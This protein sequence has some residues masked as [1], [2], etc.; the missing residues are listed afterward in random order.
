M[1]NR[2]AANDLLGK[3]IN[4]WKVIAKLPKPNPIKNETGGNFS[5]CY[6][7][8]KE[9]KECFMKVLDYEKSVMGL[10]PSGWTRTMYIQRATEE[11][12]YEKE[13]SEYCRN[14]HVSNVVYYLDSGELELPGYS[15]MG[16]VSFI[17]YEKAK[18]DIRKILDFSRRI[19]LAAKLKSLS[20]RLKS[21]H[22]TAVGISQLHN[23]AVSHQDIKPSNI[24]VFE[25][26]SKLGDLG[27]SLCLSSDVKCPYNLEGFNG[28]WTY[29]PPEAF[30]GFLLPDIR[31]RLYQMDNYMLGG[32]VFYYISGTSINARINAHLAISIREM[33]AQG[34]H[35]EEALADLQNAFHEVLEEFEQEDLLI[36]EIKE[37]LVRIVSYLCNPDPEKRGHPRSSSSSE[38]SSKYNLERTIQELD[39]LQKKAEIAISRK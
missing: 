12:N 6:I 34:M 18:G 14:K 37:D 16:T 20:I 7:V 4:D 10:L 1:D 31:F 30:F 15:I 27:R 13:L 28:D 19:E 38:L 21:L 5:I 3:T 22:D 29:A 36:D 33:L 8:E 9:G 39:V 23:N 32:L 24:M 17:I 2:F 25:T 26:E 35:F 11:F